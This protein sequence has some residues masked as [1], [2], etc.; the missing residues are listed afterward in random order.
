MANKE[1]KLA[2]HDFDV[3]IEPI[4]TE[5]SMKL[6]QDYNKVTVKVAKGTNKVQ[7][8]EAFEKLFGV[9]VTN[10]NT[11]YVRAKAKRMGRYEGK[12]SGYKKAIITLAE[13]QTLDL[14]K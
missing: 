14:V 9:K 4:V 12:V 13:G 10:V 1:V 7:I 11:S 6:T 5:K 2:I 3:I 8:K